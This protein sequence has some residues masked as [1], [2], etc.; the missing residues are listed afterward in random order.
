M[1]KFIKDLKENMKTMKASLKE[2]TEYSNTVPKDLIDYM[3]ECISKNENFIQKD[4]I[5]ILT[6]DERRELKSIKTMNKH[7][8]NNLK[9]CLHMKK[10][11]TEFNV[12]EMKGA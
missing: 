4:L 11:L 6:K 3:D 1:K 2:L 12:T 7:Y 9:D 8:I 5:A 10:V